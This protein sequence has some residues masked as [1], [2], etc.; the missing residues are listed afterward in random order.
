M[1]YDKYMMFNIWNLFLET[2]RS[3]LEVH[4]V[5]FGEAVIFLFYLCSFESAL[6]CLNDNKKKKIFLNKNWWL[7]FT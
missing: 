6:Q 3:P 7:Q 2:F 4:I 1:V 5:R